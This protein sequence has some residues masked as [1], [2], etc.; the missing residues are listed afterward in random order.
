MSTPSTEAIRLACVSSGAG[1][2]VL[3]I[4]GVYGS[5]FTLDGIRL[6]LESGY[7]VIAP[8]MRGHAGSPDPGGPLDADTLARDLIDLLDHLDVPTTHVVGYSHGGGT[9]QALARL[10]PD[11][12]RS[13]VL[14]STYA[15]QPLTTRERILG[16]IAPPVVRV[17][18]TPP[19]AA[20]IRTTRYSAGGP[21]LSAE[22][23]H[24]FC[25]EVARSS[26]GNMARALVGA[27]RFDSRPWL[28]ELTMPTLVIHGTT[29]V[30]VSHR[31]SDLLVAG[32]PG[33]RRV[34]IE[35]GGHLAP[36]THETEVVRALRDWLDEQ[37]TAT[38]PLAEHQRH[39]ESVPSPVAADPL[40]AR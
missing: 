18:R 11:R 34:S 33:A 28:A 6:S 30:L 13:L 10:A 16:R 38:R 14:M 4:H 31:Q 27:R 3:L 23:A 37:E 40:T 21:Q 9:A 26:A 22:Q 39:D 15:Y 20:G 32:I 35:G 5:G 36:I 1:E 25:Q 29:D 12:V 24:A 17:V 8:D 7:H 19:I 2:P